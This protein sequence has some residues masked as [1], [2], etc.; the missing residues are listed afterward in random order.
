MHLMLE[1]QDTQTKREQLYRELTGPLRT[2]GPPVSIEDL[3]APAW[4]HGDEEAFESTMAATAR[5]D[6]R[7]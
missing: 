4:W 1:Q 7:R 6:G 5:Y 2:V 3:N